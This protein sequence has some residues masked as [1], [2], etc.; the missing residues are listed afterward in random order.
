MEQA[1]V[2]AA[3]EVEEVPE[4]YDRQVGSDRGCPQSMGSDKEMAIGAPQRGV[5]G[6]SLEWFREMGLVFLNYFTL[7]PAG[8]TG[9]S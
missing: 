4:G 1:A 8:M 6:M 7:L 2:D 3:C 5:V 9:K